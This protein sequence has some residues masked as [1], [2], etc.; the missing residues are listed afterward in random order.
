MNTQMEFPITTSQSLLSFES[1]LVDDFRGIS[2]DSKTISVQL[3]NLKSFKASDIA[4][5]DK[6]KLLSRKKLPSELSWISS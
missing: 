5:L 4:P 3:T 2:I 1:S 6:Q